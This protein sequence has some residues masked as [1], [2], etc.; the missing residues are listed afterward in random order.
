MR[1]FVRQRGNTFTS[2]WSTVDAATGNRKQH[3]K[4]GF[5]TK[6]AANSYLNEVV[7]KVETGAWKPDTALTVKALL[8]EHWLPAQGSRGLKPSTLAQYSDVVSAWIVPNLGGMRA[9]ALTP[10]D[11][12]TLVEK[13][14]TTRTSQR[15]EG[16]SARSL[17]L[18]VGVLKAAYAFAV[19]T[20][21]LGRNPIAGVR[22]PSV[23]QRPPT[24][25]DEGTAR[26]F[27]AATRDDRLAALW[28]L[29]LTRG[30]RRGELAGLRWSAVDLAAGT[31]TVTHTLV[32]VDGHVQESTPKTRAGRRSVP[33]D[34]GLVSLLTAHR[35]AQGAERLRAG[36][37]KDER[38]YVFTNELGDPLSPD[39]VSERFEVLVK[40]AGLPRIRLHDTRHTAASLMIAAGVPAKVVQE[41]LGHSHVSIT[42]ALYAHVTPA[43]GREAGAALS[44]SLLGAQ[45]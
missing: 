3:T 9:A 2:Y 14:R 41:M 29:A 5:A 44:A 34:D 45:G 35:K 39:W 21:L 7:G 37:G 11:V 43:M 25:W 26:A 22:R 30:L 40:A 6:K 13:L 36:L 28:A 20:E 31:L 1:G 15:R 18:T 8:E 16:L 27:L 23:E 38:G 12:Q 17:Q 19:T 24:T 33:L 32:M 42:L 10:K 4:G